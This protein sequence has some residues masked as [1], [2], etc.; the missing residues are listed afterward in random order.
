[1][2]TPASVAAAARANITINAQSKSKRDVFSDLPDEDP[3]RNEVI[4]ICRTAN[5]AKMR[6]TNRRPSAAI[7][8]LSAK[9]YVAM[10][11]AIKHAA[12][13]ERRKCLGSRV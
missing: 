8:D 12:G 7:F 13:Y 6:P 11:E 3:N 1:M 9:A 10:L 5:P 2:N 4:W